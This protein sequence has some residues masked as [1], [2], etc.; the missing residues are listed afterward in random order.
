MARSVVRA[1]DF[2]SSPSLV[3]AAAAADHAQVLHGNDDEEYD[4]SYNII[5]RYSLC[6]FTS[7]V[8]FI[9]WYLLDFRIVAAFDKHC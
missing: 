1:Y 9:V 3:L 7:K 8:I 6:V 2:Y 4:A 5:C